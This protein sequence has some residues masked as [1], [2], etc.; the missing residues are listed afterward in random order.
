MRGRREYPLA[1]GA[2]AAHR[3]ARGLLHLRPV[4]G[5]R[6]DLRRAPRAAD[7][8]R[9]GAEP[10]GP[11]L[12]A[13]PDA[14]APAREGPG[15]PAGLDP[16][17]LLQ[18]RRG[19]QLA[20]LPRLLEAPLPPV[21]ATGW[22]SSTCRSP[23]RRS[24]RGASSCAARTTPRCSGTRSS[25]SASSAA[26]ASAARRSCARSPPRAARSARAWPSSTCRASTSPS[27][28][29]PGRS[30]STST[31][32]RTAGWSAST[33]RPASTRS[34]QGEADPKAHFACHYSAAL[35]ELVAEEIAAALAR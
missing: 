19:A 7:R 6:G 28:A 34:S 30:A 33:R 18:R 35:H 24:S 10:R 32:A 31:C 27:S 20:L 16:A 29:R 4:R 17:R 1:H 9:R 13:R 15:V 25:P 8:A 5:R 21:A 11:R 26:T 23:R 3:R 22:S 2:G 14:A 12:R